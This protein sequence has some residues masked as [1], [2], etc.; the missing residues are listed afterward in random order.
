[1]LVLLSRF[2][3]NYCK[4]GYPFSTNFY[5]NLIKLL[6]KSPL[7]TKNK[8][9]IFSSKKNEMVLKDI[10][11]GQKFQTLLVLGHK[12]FGRSQFR[13][14]LCTKLCLKLK[15]SEIFGN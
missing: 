10:L 14:K 7:E 13:T 9:R 2:G 11:K 1:M 4:T 3:S 8:L 5:P 15:T 12:N 6:A